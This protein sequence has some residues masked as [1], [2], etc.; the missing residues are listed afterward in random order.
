MLHQ[1]KSLETA[2]G[3]R[4]E[5]GRRIR[6][7][8]KHFSQD[9]SFVIDRH[10]E[11]MR[12]KFEREWEEERELCEERQRGRERRI[13]EIAREEGERRER[14]WRRWRKRER[15]L[16]EEIERWERFERE[17]ERL[18]REWGR[19]ERE[20]EERVEDMVLGMAAFVLS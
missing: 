12:E 10:E 5:A 7:W 2:P 20:E 4:D 9:R 1:A 8:R 19:F 11:W 16:R 14:Y 3:G 17:W 18:E 13:A 15:R 6:R